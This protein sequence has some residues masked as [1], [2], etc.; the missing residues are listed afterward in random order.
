MIRNEVEHK[1][2]A[3]NSGQ[4]LLLVL[5]LRHASKLFN[6]KIL[7]YGVSYGASVLQVSSRYPRGAAGQNST[8]CRFRACYLLRTH[9]IMPDTF[10]KVDF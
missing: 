5:Y 7:R 9:F 3:P 10:L 1:V 6:L 4:F 8:M 2:G